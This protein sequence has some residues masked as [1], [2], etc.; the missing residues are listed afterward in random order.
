MRE[1]TINTQTEEELQCRLNRGIKLSEFCITEKELDSDSQQEI[2]VSF[3]LGLHATDLRIPKCMH[4]TSFSE[5]YLQYCLDLAEVRAANSSSSACSLPVPCNISVSLK[6]SEY[7]GSFDSILEPRQHIS[8]STSDLGP[9]IIQC[10][11]STR[12]GQW[13]VSTVEGNQSARSIMNDPL[14]H[15]SALNTFMNIAEVGLVDVKRTQENSRMSIPSRFSVSLPK[16]LETETSNFGNQKYGPKSLTEQ[17]FTISE[18]NSIGSYQSFAPSLSSP[19]TYSQGILRCEFET[20][21]PYF[22]YSVDGQKEVYEAKILKVESSDNKDVDYV[23]SFYTKKG[24]R[25]DDLVGRMKVSSSLRLCSDLNNA[26]FKETEFVLFS[27]DAKQIA[28]LSSSDAVLGKQVYQNKVVDIFRPKHVRKHRSSF[29]HGVQNSLNSCEDDVID[30]LAAIIVKEQ[31]RDDPQTAVGGWGL[32]FLEKARVERA[33]TSQEASVSSRDCV[34]T[35]S[36]NESGCAR[37]VSVIIPAGFHGGPRTRIG[38]PSRLTERWKS[39]GRCD[40]G[41]WDLGCP[42]TILSNQSSTEVS[43]HDKAEDQSLDLVIKGTK[44]RAPTLKMVNINDGKYQIHF[45]SS[46][47]TLQSFS[48]GVAMIHARTQ[49]LC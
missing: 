8:K 37:S 48:I 39:G 34:E 11:S 45:Q 31:V 17:P 20:G 5:S 25:L 49:S 9:F 16:K 30:E 22:L 41:G 33:N 10:P 21:V 44:Q 29:K 24:G 4:F 7:D 32:K 12:S 47:S 13:I 35:N 15:L 38:G 28:N 36:L 1:E 43:A 26:N 2:E 46:L 27:V 18:A 6:S 19:G 23:Y 42:F 40:C 14:L 3:P